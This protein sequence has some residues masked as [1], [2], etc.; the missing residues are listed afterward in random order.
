MASALTGIPPF[1]TMTAA[2][3]ASPISTSGIPRHRTLS[4]A[5]KMSDPYEHASTATRTT[6]SP[7]ERPLGNGSSC[8][9]RPTITSPHHRR[10][11]SSNR[12]KLPFRSRPRTR[13]NATTAMSRIIWERPDRPTIT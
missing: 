6:R 12:R 5:N 13:A 2:F 8:R 11:R 7:L 10:R 9:A 3:N 1:A 4:A